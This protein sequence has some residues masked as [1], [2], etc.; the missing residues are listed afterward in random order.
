MSTLSVPKFVLYIDFGW[1]AI[2]FC[3]CVLELV[4]PGF[5]KIQTT[6]RH[7]IFNCSRSRH[8]CFNSTFAYVIVCDILYTT[9]TMHSIDVLCISKMEA[10][11]YIRTVL[12]FGNPDESW[13][14]SILRASLTDPWLV[15]PPGLLLLP[16]ANQQL[17]GV[18][19]VILATVAE[20]GDFSNG[21]G[22]WTGWLKQVKWFGAQ[23][24]VKWKKQIFI[25][26]M[27]ILLHVYISSCFE[28]AKW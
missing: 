8:C 20:H 10:T 3:Q 19:I 16:G 26:S 1:L 11:L 25:K 28:Q 5:K 18:S 9:M 13:R 22:C 4:L 27:L 7:G 23:Q 12:P 21:F 17:L 14:F 15:R 24:V 6:R 2:C